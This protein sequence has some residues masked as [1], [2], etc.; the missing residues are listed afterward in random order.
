AAQQP[1]AAPA[2]APTQPAAPAANGGRR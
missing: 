1:A 2:P